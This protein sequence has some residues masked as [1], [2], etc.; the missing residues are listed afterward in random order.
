[1]LAV[2]APT[3]LLAPFVW[4]GESVA[5]RA[6]AERRSGAASA[7][8]VRP[9]ARVKPQYLARSYRAPPQLVHAGA[10][11]VLR[12][13]SLRLDVPVDAVG[14]DG[15]A[16]AVP[17]DPGRVGWLSTT[18]AAGD[19][20][21]SSVLAGHVSDR[22]DHPGAL[23]D[24]RKVRIGAKVEWVDRQ[25]SVHRFR[26]ASLQVFPRA[27]GL[28][29]SLFATDGPHV[30]RLVTCAERVTTKDGGFHYRSNLVVTAVR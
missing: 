30:L 25:G 8:A 3:L 23:A 14:L 19:V 12:V 20:V 29:A 26:V 21:G 2:L 6:Q 13:P 15:A 9:T 24:L 17:D 27:K 4:R 28:P 18:A 11:G 22:H 10:G 16:M 5:V 7:P 1:M